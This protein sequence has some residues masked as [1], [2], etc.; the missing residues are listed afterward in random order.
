MET[1]IKIRNLRFWT[2][3]LVFIGII[4]PFTSIPLFWK[5]I[6]AII[7]LL[8]GFKIFLLENDKELIEKE[9]KEINKLLDEI[10]SNQPGNWDAFLKL[11]KKRTSSNF[12]KSRL[13]AKRKVNELLGRKEFAS[14]LKKSITK[15]TRNEMINIYKSNNSEKYDTE[16]AILH[17]KNLKEVIEFKQKYSFSIIMTQMQL[18]NHYCGTNF[19]IHELEKTLGY[20]KELLF[21]V[22][23]I[24]END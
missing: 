2:G 19:K 6:I 13:Y 1:N 12:E 22:G 16:I 9:I 10:I 8:A 21:E 3:V 20:Y 4:I 11:R 18:A 23:L 24:K 14:S 5:I 17:Y 15:E 7:V